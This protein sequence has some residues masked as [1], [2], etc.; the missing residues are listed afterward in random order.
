MIVCWNDFLSAM[1]FEETFA[2]FFDIPFQKK[3]EDSFCSRIMKED[4]GVP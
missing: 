4:N 3:E 2:S 1:N